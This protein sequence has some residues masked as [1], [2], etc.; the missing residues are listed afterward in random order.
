MRVVL[1]C[2][3]VAG[4]FKGGRTIGRLA[5]GLG[6]NAVCKLLKRGKDNGAALV[7][8]T[9][10]LAGPARKRVLFRKRPLDCCS[11]TSVTCVSA[12]PFFCDCVGMGSIRTCCT[13]FFRSFSERRFEGAVRH[14]N[15]GRRV[16]TSTVSDK[17]GTGLGTTTAL[18][19][20]T[21]LLLLS[22][23]L[24]N[25]SCGTERRVVT[26]VLRR[27]SRGHAVIVSAR[28]VRRMRDFV[29]S[30]V[31]VGSKRLI[32]IIGIRAREVAAKGSLTRLCLRGVWKKDVSKGVGRV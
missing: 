29:R 6:G 14:L 5:L 26:L 2:E 30:T 28:L 19:E 32:S 21:S 9:T 31:F 11:G 20:G 17:V 4:G 25:I 18:T 8:V 10:K 22:R 7:G 16:G 3:D 23:P 27:T 12:R 13:S 1:R 15:L 24:G